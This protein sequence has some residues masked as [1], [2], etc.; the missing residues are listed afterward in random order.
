MLIKLEVRNSQ[1]DLLTLSLD[2]ISSGFLIKDIA[3][4]GPVKATIVTSDFADLDGTFYQG[5]S[6]EN[7]NIRLQLELKPDYA[8]STVQELRTRLYRFFMT[9]SVV[10][11]RFFMTNG[12]TVDISGMV[13]T[14]EPTIFAREPAVDISIICFDPD[15]IESDSVV[16]EGESTAG[17][18]ELII[19][20]DGTVETGF[21][22]TF[23]IDRTLGEFT[24]YHKLPDDSLKV[25]GFE[26]PLIAGDVLTIN[27][28]SGSRGASLVRAGSI[29]SIFYGIQQPFDWLELMQG[30]NSFRVYAVGAAV[31]YSV[32]Y[33][34][35]YGAL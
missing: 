30:D 1:G 9:K 35:R 12:L 32:E 8:V 26:A 6:R 10:M 20:Y 34:T 25:L 29:S 18:D 11:F 16:V 28:I 15:F 27:T 3:G 14:V 13:E 7:R 23:N 22:F 31:P 4:M 24:I 21:I 33:I 17:T 5:S 19:P 2:D